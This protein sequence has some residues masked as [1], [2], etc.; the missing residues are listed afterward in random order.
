MG[1]LKTAAGRTLRSRL[2]AQNP[3]VFSGTARSLGATTTNTTSIDDSTNIQFSTSYIAQDISQVTCHDP[4]LHSSPPPPPQPNPMQ[5]THLVDSIT[6]SLRTTPSPS[7]RY[8][9]SL[10]LAYSSNPSHWS[11]FAHANPN[12]QYTRNLVCEVPGLFNLLI[13]VWTPGKASPVHD[14]ADSHCLMKVLQGELRETRFAIP[15]KPGMNKP[16]EETSMLGYGMDKV[17]YMSDELGLHSVGNPH[18]TD[19]AVSL[20]L[21]TPPNAAMRGCHVYDTQDGQSRHVL[22]AAYD[23]VRGVVSASQN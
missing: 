11:K 18:P 13:L 8:L 19:Y 10:L 12:K 7:I 14:H 17:S 23:S 5:F 4:F 2:I 1:S 20:H 15:S 21:Y 22:Q 3:R 16:L 9:R 6:N